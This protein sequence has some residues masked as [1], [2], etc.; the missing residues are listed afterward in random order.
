MTNSTKKTTIEALRAQG[1]TLLA[2]ADAMESEA[3]E[4]PTNDA[5]GELLTVAE[6]AKLKK[7]SVDTIRRFVGEGCPHSRVGARARFVL[8]DV[9]RWL[10]SRTRKTRDGSAPVLLSRGGGR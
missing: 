6:L 2:L 8:A 1:R 4:Q 9:D 3:A 7:C 5:A 10:A